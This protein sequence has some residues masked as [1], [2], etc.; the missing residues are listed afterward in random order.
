MRGRTQR[1]AFL[2]GRL[3]H[4]NDRVYCNVDALYEPPQQ[5]LGGVATVVRDGEVEAVDVLAAHLGMA[6]VGYTPNQSTYD[7]L[8]AHTQLTHGLS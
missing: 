5:D 6:R 7:G 8:A 3:A 2:Y 1:C 4:V